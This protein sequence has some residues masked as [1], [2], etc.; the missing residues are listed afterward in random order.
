[1]PPARQ[2]MLTEDL[3]AKTLRPEVDPGPDADEVLLGDDEFVTEAE[4]FNAEA[5]DELWIFAYGSLI[6][7]PVFEPEETRLAVAHGWHRSFCMPLRRWRGT[8]SQPGLMM[9]VQRGGNCKGVA[10]RIRQEERLSA[11]TELLRRE[12]NTPENLRFA[13]WITCVIHGRKVRTL[14]FWVGPTG[15]YVGEK[16]SLEQVAD[17]LSRACGHVGSG[18]EYLYNTVAHLEQLGI[19]DRNLWRLQELVALRLGAE[20]PGAAPVTSEAEPPPSLGQ[21]ARLRLG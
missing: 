2:M 8:P 21:A 10:F 1:M 18:A 17:T 16:Q 3:V 15:R 4:R 6:W 19:H 13:R 20:V 7:K 11:L 12:V 5:G 14:C 9:A